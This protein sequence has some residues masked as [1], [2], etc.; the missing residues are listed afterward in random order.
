MAER[1]KAHVLTRNSSH[2]GWQPS[3]RGCSAVLDSITPQTHTALAPLACTHR[4]ARVLLTSSRHL[5]LS[6][7]P[8]QL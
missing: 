2:T 8:L 4:S 7:C 3:I 1:R 6:P 5:A